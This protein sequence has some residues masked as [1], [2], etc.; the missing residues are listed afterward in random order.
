MIVNQRYL[1]PGLASRSIFRLLHGKNEPSFAGR[2]I[3]PAVNL[4]PEDR[5]D[6]PAVVPVE[7]LNTVCTI[8][9]REALPS[10]PFDSFFTGYSMMED[11]ALSLRVGQKWRLANVRTA[12]VV[13]ESQSGMEKHRASAF[14][15]MELVNR[16]YVMR[17]VMGRQRLSDFGRLVL[18]EIFTIA[19]SLGSKGGL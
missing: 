15:A 9:R 3:G 17:N 13:H 19:S 1:A 16:H 6:L 12:R 11:L 10:P 5:D 18:W 2:V 7:W 8:Y 14:H 4:L